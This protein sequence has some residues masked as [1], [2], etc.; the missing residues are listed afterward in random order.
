MNR[1]FFE[2]WGNYFTNVAKGQKQLEEM[3]AWMKKG[4][5]GTDELTQLFRR[6]YGLE[7]PEP[8]SSLDSQKWQ[9]AI[10][11]FQDTFSQTAN[12]WGW[13]T[14]TEHQQIIDKC[15]ALEEKIQQQEKTINQLRDLLDKEGLGHSELFQHVKDVY[16]DQSKQFQELMKSINEAVSN[17]S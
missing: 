8:N 5:S 1:Q 16:E 10:A 6:C 13:V 4:F 2:F 3:S 12:A 17:K 9:K 14:K 7:E 15:S 11:E